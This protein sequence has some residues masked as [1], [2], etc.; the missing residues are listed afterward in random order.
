MKRVDALNDTVGLLLDDRD[1]ITAATLMPPS[2]TPVV[3]VPDDM[4][5]I[6]SLGVEAGRYLEFVRQSG[7]LAL[8]FGVLLPGLVLGAVRAE[9]PLAVAAAW[10]AVAVAVFLVVFHGWTW[11]TSRPRRL[12]D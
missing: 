3:T 11:W 4:L 5:P 8:V 9:G 2:G 6:L 7:F 1:R 12:Q 10:L